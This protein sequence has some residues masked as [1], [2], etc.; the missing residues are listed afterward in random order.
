MKELDTIARL[1]MHHPDTANHSV[2]AEQLRPFTGRRVGVVRLMLAIALENPVITP[3]AMVERF[4]GHPEQDWLY[5]LL[6][7]GFV[8]EQKQE[9][10]NIW[11]RI[12]QECEWNS[13]RQKIAEALSG[14][15]EPNASE[16]HAATPCPNT[17]L[18]SGA[19]SATTG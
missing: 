14:L 7:P 3:A 10:K 18:T 9:F 1:I 2:D 12:K 13:Q 19:R 15:S 11:A 4:R 16:S 8:D 17:G 6:I 5:G